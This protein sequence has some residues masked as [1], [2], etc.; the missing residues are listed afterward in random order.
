MRP[1]RRSYSTR[2]RRPKSACCCR[3]RRPPT[4]PHWPKSCGRNARRSTSWPPRSSRLT[5]R[6]R[7]TMPPGA[8]PW[9]TITSAVVAVGV[10]ATGFLAWHATLAK[11][12]KDVA[13]TPPA[14]EQTKPAAPPVVTTPVAA[15]PAPPAPQPPPAPQSPMQ[16][17]AAQTAVV[18]PPPTGSEAPSASPVPPP[19]P[20]L[21]TPRIAGPPAST[22]SGATGKAALRPGPGVSGRGVAPGFRHAA[23]AA[24]ETAHPLG[25]DPTIARCAGKRGGAAAG[26]PGRPPRPARLGAAI[27]GHRDA[28]Q[29]PAQRALRTAAA[30]LR[31]R[32]Q[33][34]GRRRHF[35]QR[36]TD[37][38][39]FRHRRDGRQGEDALPH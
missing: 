28:A 20:V 39:R 24:A 37:G 25:R 32:L 5:G 38:P 13:A 23:G 12:E 29:R 34:G 27:V 4:T 1:F 16:T 18:V 15:T 8:A 10:L 19:S 22:T 3:R 9:G 26:R 14:A 2:S 21:V 36:G 31:G 6:A 35:R 33:R 30:G 11:K 7:R 17:L